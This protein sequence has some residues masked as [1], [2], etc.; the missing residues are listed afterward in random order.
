MKMARHLALIKC[1]ALCITLSV[2]NVPNPCIANLTFVEGVNSLKSISCSNMADD[3]PQMTV[4]KA[5]DR[6]KTYE[7]FWPFY[8]REHSKEST[9]HLHYV[10][11]S[12][13]LLVVGTAAVT[14]RPGLL[15]AVPFAG[16]ALYHPALMC[17]F[18]LKLMFTRECSTMLPL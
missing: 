7:E 5:D 17:P 10:G 6:L 12:L 9:R 18:R 16:A 8:L 13:A 14:R 15:L 11:S 1:S 2:E 4:E 3:V